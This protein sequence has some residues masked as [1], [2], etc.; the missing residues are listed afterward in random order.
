MTYEELIVAIDDAAP[1]LSEASLRLLLRLVSLAIQNGSN[2]IRISHRDLADAMKMSREGV[3]RAARGLS[4]IVAIDGGHKVT[5]TF[6][7]PADWFAPQRSLFAVSGVVDNISN[8]PTY[9]ARSGQQTRPALANEPGQGGQR[10]RPG[11]QPTRPDLAYEPGHV[12]NEPGQSG[13]RPRPGIMQNQQ[14]SADPLDRSSR[15]LSSIVDL[16]T[17]SESIERVNHIPEELAHDARLLKKWLKSYFEGH[18][19]SHTAPDG[20]DE[21]ILAKCL[22]IS[23]LARLAQTLTTLDK[24]GTRPGETW[25]WFVTVFCQRIHRTKYPAQVAAPPGFIQPKKTPSS[26]RGGGFSA[27]LLQEVA[28]G[29]HFN[30]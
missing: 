23:P 26:E 18:H 28:A 30:F 16:P 6:T 8:W 11:G 15:D 27:D 2:E 19:P 1:T 7:L 4:G 17:P 24:K 29:A 10:A 3:A 12:A 14:L 9:Q 20:P 21:I 5:S 13:Q 25:A 22:A